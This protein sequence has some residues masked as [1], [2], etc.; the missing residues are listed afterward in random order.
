MPVLTGSGRLGAPTGLVAAV[1]PADEPDIEREH[2]PSGRTARTLR[3]WRT[4]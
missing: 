2:R 4:V 3:S 1:A